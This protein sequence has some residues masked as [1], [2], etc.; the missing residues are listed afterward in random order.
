MFSR[1]FQM[2]YKKKSHWEYEH[3]TSFTRLNAKIENDYVSSSLIP[4][5]R[6]AHS[7]HFLFN[8]TFH[9]NPLYLQE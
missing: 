2:S 6:C 5:L 3:Q 9:N 4:M 7:L 1:N 8:N